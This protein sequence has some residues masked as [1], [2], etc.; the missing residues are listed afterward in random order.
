MSGSII[1]KSSTEKSKVYLLKKKI[2]ILAVNYVSY[3]LFISTVFTLN[4]KK[5]VKV[6]HRN[7][8][9]E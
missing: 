6:G 7:V 2:R 5:T 4:I 3:V 9:S 8:I 1:N